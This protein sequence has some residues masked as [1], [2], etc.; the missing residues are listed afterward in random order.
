MK[1]WIISFFAVLVALYSFWVSLGI[2][3]TAVPNFALDLKDP[4][5]YIENMVRRTM[6]V[7][8]E[9][10]TIL[11]ADLVKHFPSDDSM[12]LLKPYLQLY[13]TVGEPWHVMSETGWVSA[14]NEVILL[15]GE[16]EIWRLDSE[17]NRV[18]Q[19]LTSELRVLPDD[20]YAESD[21]PSIIIH[22]SAVTHSIGLRANFSHNHLE[23]V[24]QVRSKHK[25]KTSG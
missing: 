25:N 1:I 24:R 15:H 14:G 21:Q 19:A 13:N 4:D 20:E 18:I 12:E 7:N 16:V 10:G 11:Y 23:L 6:N 9:I 5:Y 3:E 8:G 17:K 22:P 2:E